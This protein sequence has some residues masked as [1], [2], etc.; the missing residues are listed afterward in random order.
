MKSKDVRAV[1][2][3]FHHEYSVACQ[4][5]RVPYLVTSQM[6]SD[7]DTNAF[8]IELFPNGGLF[9]QAVLDV[10]KYYRYKKVAVVYHSSA[11]TLFD[12]PILYL[13]RASRYSST[14][15]GQGLLCDSGGA[16]NSLDF[17][18][19]LLKSLGCF[20]FRCVLSPLLY[21]A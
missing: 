17:C 3:P 7:L 14:I 15:R 11:G 10:I 16:V 9:S 1:I 20:Y 4:H 21:T 12:S 2:G 13:S 19:A 8:L 5:L 18:P 6:P